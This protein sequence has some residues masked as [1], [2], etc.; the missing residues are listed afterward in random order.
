MSTL[1][2]LEYD[3][4]KHSQQIT[5]VFE[6]PELQR[7]FKLVRMMDVQSQRLN[8]LEKAKGYIAKQKWKTSYK[9][10]IADAYK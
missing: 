3:F 6:L 5:K 8:R 9:E 10:N 1:R 4:Q 7:C 2:K